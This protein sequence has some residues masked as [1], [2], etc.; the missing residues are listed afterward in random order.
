MAAF[1]NRPRKLDRG[2]G[3]TVHFCHLRSE[4][5]QKWFSAESL[6]S[7][8]ADEFLGRIE[9]SMPMDVVVQP[10]FEGN[11]IAFGNVVLKVRNIGIGFLEQH[12]SIEVP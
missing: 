10:F 7:G 6:S 1:F 3:N 9:S 11:E 12:G 2:T 4:R 8:S 5:M